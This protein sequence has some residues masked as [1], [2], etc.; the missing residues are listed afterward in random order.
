MNIGLNA[1][2]PKGR[3]RALSLAKLL[4]RCEDVK[5]LVVES[6]RELLAVNAA[7]KQDLKSRDSLPASESALRISEAIQGNMQAAS[8]KLSV[9]VNALAGC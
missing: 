8:E 3:A 5:V 4:Q 9:V 7:V 6:A 1:D 2:L